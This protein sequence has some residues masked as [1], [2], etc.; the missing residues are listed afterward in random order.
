M[1]SVTIETRIRYR[2]VDAVIYELVSLSLIF[3]TQEKELNSRG[4]HLFNIRKNI[5]GTIKAE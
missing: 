5:K 1:L 4:T 3:T 2:V